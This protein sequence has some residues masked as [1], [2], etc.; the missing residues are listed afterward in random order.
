MKT[1]MRTTTIFLLILALWAW[2]AFFLT[3]ERV[4]VSIE[5]IPPGPLQALWE[6]PGQMPKTLLVL[7]PGDPMIKITQLPRQ[8]LWEKPG[9]APRTMPAAPPGFVPED[10]LVKIT[11]LPPQV[12][13]EEPGKAPKTIFAL[14]PDFVPEDP[15]VKITP[16]P[17]EKSRVV[18][19][20][21]PPARLQGSG[22]ARFLLGSGK[23]I[24]LTDWP[25]FWWLMLPVAPL[26]GLAWLVTKARKN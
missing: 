17:L 9:E 1:T 25:L 16:L 21:V 19:R 24:W 8:V 20:P 18:V 10:P 5:T 2:T 11:P 3:S 4:I 13:W 12:V 26:A 7:P 14:P 23:K 15:L 6:E 22:E